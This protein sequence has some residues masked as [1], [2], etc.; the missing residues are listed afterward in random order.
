MDTLTADAQAEHFESWAFVEIFG[1]SKLAGKVTARK[2]GADVMFQV[3]VPSV[4]GGFAYSRL[5]NPKAVFALQPT[6]EDW[7]RR[8][9]KAAAEYSA[10]VLP[11]IPSEPERPK[12]EEGAPI[13]DQRDY[14]DD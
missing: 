4:D 14:D 6:N 9:A 12:L 10:P 13:A 1:H 11:Y 8:W 3:D 2:F 7:C 5:L